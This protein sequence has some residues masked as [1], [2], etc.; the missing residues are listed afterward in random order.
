VKVWVTVQD[1]KVMLDARVPGSTPLALEI[2]EAIDLA[3]EM[4]GAAMIAQPVAQVDD[5]PESVRSLRGSAS[6]A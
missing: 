2:G 5:T 1:G 4:L 6:S 3:S